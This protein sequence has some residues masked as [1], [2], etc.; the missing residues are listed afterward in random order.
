MS[1]E[2]TDASSETRVTIMRKSVPLLVTVTPMD[3]TAWGNRLRACC[4]LFCTCIWATSALV[5]A[6]KLRPTLAEPAL[7]VADML[8]KP[9][10]P[11]ICCSMT[12]VTESSMVWALAPV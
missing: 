12:W 1:A 8:S 3:C 11:F 7:E 10:R 2:V 9:S 4:T 6:T 5:P